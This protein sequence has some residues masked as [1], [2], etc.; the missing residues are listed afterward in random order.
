MSAFAKDIKGTQ[1]FDATVP[2]KGQDHL[3]RDVALGEVTNE[4]LTGADLVDVAV[5][6]KVVT[7]KALRNPADPAVPESATGTLHIDGDPG[8]EIVDVP[9][10]W[11]V[12]VSSGVAAV[13][14]VT[15]GDAVEQP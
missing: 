6:G 2:D 8:T 11:M 7:F 1:Q 3:G 4:T 5:N 10:S 13:V 9:V 14:N 15:V 12:N